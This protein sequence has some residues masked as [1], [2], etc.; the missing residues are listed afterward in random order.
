MYLYVREYTILNWFIDFFKY[1]YIKCK[2]NY[3][4]SI[5]VDCNQN[6]YSRRNNNSVLINISVL[7]HR[8]NYL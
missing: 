7:Y 5:H 3:Y 6:S 8:V 4:L 1:V 2:Y